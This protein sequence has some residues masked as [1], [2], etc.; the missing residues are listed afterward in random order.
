M[1]STQ[2]IVDEI[3]KRLLKEEEIDKNANRES[4]E[5][6]ADLFLHLRDHIEKP[7]HLIESSRKSFGPFGLSSN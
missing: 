5:D 1:I 7:Y 6:F 3:L 2:E 4:N